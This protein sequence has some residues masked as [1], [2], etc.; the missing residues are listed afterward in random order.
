MPSNDPDTSEPLLKPS[1]DECFLCKKPGDGG[2]ASLQR[3]SRCRTVPYCSRECQTSDWKN[4]KKNCMAFVM[5]NAAD[6][7]ST[8]FGEKGRLKKDREHLRSRA[9][10]VRDLTAT[11]TEHNGDTFSVVIWHAMNLLRD[12]NR[13]KTHFFAI[14]LTRNFSATNPRALHTLVDAAVLPLSILEDKFDKMGVAFMNAS[15]STHDPPVMFSPVKVLRD[16]AEEEKRKG[17][18]GAALTIC[19]ELSRKE[20][21]KSVEQAV[22]DTSCPTFHPLGL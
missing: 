19:V 9:D 17:A 1:K 15:G 7:T 10:I 11:A 6:S 8:N 16:S 13:A 5:L 22:K 14:T 2:P 3:C 18:L 4:H 12:I 21:G 20:K